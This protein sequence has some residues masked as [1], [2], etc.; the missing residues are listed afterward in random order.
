MLEA[1]PGDRLFRYDMSEINIGGMQWVDGV[2]N[3]EANEGSLTVN[4][5]YSFRLLKNNGS[6]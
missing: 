2:R 4:A 5:G 1:D 6:S 3:F